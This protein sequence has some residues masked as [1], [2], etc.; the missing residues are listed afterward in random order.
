MRPIYK[1]IYRG[2]HGSSSFYHWLRRRFTLAGLCVVGGALVSGSVG[3]DIDN[4]VTYQV[5]ALLLAML[6][7]ALGTSRFFHAK[8]SASRQLP[9]FGTVG[10]RLCYRLQVKNLTVRPQMGLVVLENSA[11]PRP[12]FEE[13]LAFQLAEN[14]RV[15]PFRLSDRRP[16]PFRIA[17]IKEAEVPPLAP[18]GEAEVR[19]DMLPLRRGIVRFSG[20]TLARTDPFGLIRSFV[21]TPAVNSILILPKRYDLPAVPLPGIMKYQENG[22]ALAANIGRSEEFVSLREYRRGDPV[23]HIHW[24]SWAKAGKP[25]VKE[26]ED[27]F[28]VRHALVLDT[29]TTEPYGEILEEAV[30][31]AASFACALITQESL[32]DLLFVGSQTYCFTAGRGLAHTGQMLE[33]LASVQA[34]PDKPFSVLESLVLNHVSVVSGVICVLQSWDEARRN[35]VQKLRALNLPVVVLIVVYPRDKIPDPGPMRDS[36]EN[37]HVL[38]IGKIQEDLMTLVT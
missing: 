24:R 28:F 25:I 15:P 36:P 8:F 18:R 9:R 19:V 14:K 22:V 16:N 30:S 38:K 23:R 17:E 2:Y 5:F 13:W 1:L 12:T 4:T 34:C 21:K 3:G 37:F 32:L 29:F 11:D 7:L 31:I 33:I 20:I 26:F 6:V 35:F 10:Q 27:E